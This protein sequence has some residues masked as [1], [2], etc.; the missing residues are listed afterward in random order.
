LEKSRANKVNPERRF[1]TPPSKAGLGAAEWVNGPSILCSRG[2]PK[3]RVSTRRIGTLGSRTPA[4]AQTTRKYTLQRSVRASSATFPTF[5]YFG[6]WPPLGESSCSD[7][8]CERSAS[9][10]LISVPSG[11]KACY[12]MQGGPE[13][14]LKRLGVPRIL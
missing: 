10:V 5:P 8:Y 6:G 13:S 9:T 2:S 14:T 11:R 4:G 1:F 3:F 12:G 7:S